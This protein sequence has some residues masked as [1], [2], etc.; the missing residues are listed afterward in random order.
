MFSFKKDFAGP[1]SFMYFTSWDK[2][3]KLIRT[4]RKIPKSIY[5]DHQE[6]KKPIELSSSLYDVGTIQKFWENC[7]ETND[8]KMNYNHFDIMRMFK[9]NGNC[10]C[11]KDHDKKIYATLFSYES[12]TPIFMN[13][14]MQNVRFINGSVVNH[15]MKDEILCWLFSWMEYLIPSI[16]IYTSD[17]LP[18]MIC[19][20]Y[21]YY[22]YYAI[23]SN[24]ILDESVGTVERIP[25]S[26]FNKYQEMFIKLN[27]NKLN[28]I[29]ILNS[30]T[31]D[32]ELFKVPIQFHSNSYYIIG[33]INTKKVYKKF[34]IPIYEVIFCVTIAS[35]NHTLIN[36]SEEEKY[37]TRYAIESVCKVGNYPMLLISTKEVSGDIYDYDNSWS[38]FKLK[39]KKLYIYNYLTKGYNNSCIYFPK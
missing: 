30:D 32:I 20:P 33:V 23:S 4:T 24:F 15:K 38:K 26:D 21:T 28:L 36:P 13:N 11:L 16:Y 10:I 35:D 6:I 2:K 14:K 7:Y 3:D 9:N 34:T 5:I 37:L 29:Y 18:N 27:K 12:D 22:N 19:S 25:K 39:K 17:D 31:S 8:Y 1:T